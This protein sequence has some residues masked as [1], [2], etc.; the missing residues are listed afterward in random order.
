MNCGMNKMQE[1]SRK[2]GTLKCVFS[3]S[4]SVK[5]MQTAGGWVLGSPGRRTSDHE[6]VAQDREPPRHSDPSWKKGQTPNPSWFKLSPYQNAHDSESELVRCPTHQSTHVH[7]RSVRVCPQISRVLSHHSVE[8]GD[9]LDTTTHRTAIYTLTPET[10]PMYVNM[11]VQRQICRHRRP[12]PAPLEEATASSQRRLFSID[13]ARGGD[14]PGITAD[15]SVQACPSSRLS[16]HGEVRSTL[17]PS[18]V[19][20][21]KTHRNRS[22]QFGSWLQTAGRQ[23]SPGP[24]QPCEGATGDG[25]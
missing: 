13:G 18:E 3:R 10:T 1:R 15:P 25:T 4:M 12:T 9:L 21:P 14:V 5:L 2:L 16:T 23:P 6:C 8:K 19:H 7:F 22:G 24:L 17:R 20:H 11:P